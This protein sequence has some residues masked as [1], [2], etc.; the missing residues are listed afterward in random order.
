MYYSWILFDA[1]DYYI[2]FMIWMLTLCLS[3]CS[4]VAYNYF[5]YSNFAGSQTLSKLFSNNFFENHRLIR[6]IHERAGG[7]LPFLNKD[8]TRYS[9]YSWLANDKL[10]SNKLDLENLF[11][12]NLNKKW[13][14]TSHGY[15]L[16]LY[17]LTNFLDLSVMNK[18]KIR[19]GRGLEKIYLEESF[20]EFFNNYRLFRYL[21]S[22]QLFPSLKTYNF[23]TKSL[24]SVNYTFLDNLYDYNLMEIENQFNENSFLIKHKK[25]LF[26]LNDLNFGDLIFKNT[27]FKEFY[28]INLNF[29]NQLDSAKWNRWLYRY[30]ILHRKI[31]K[32]S[33]KLTLTKKLINMSPNED[34]SFDKNIWLS[35]NLQK[36]SNFSNFLNSFYNIFS[37]NTSLNF[38]NFQKRTLLNDINM[39]NK[40]FLNFY[41]NSFFFFLK[42]F[43]FFNELKFNNTKSS[44]NFKELYTDSAFFKKSNTADYILNSKIVNYKTFN[45]SIIA[46]NNYNNLFLKS[47]YTKSDYENKDLFLIFEDLDFYSKDNL[48][49]LYW[50]TSLPSL[51]DKVLFFNYFNYLNFNKFF[52]NT[53]FKFLSNNGDMFSEFDYINYLILNNNDDFYLN[54]LESYNNFI[55]I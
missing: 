16:T 47:F 30:S 25:G 35:E 22:F 55:N 50:I 38:N 28:N 17:K 14:N 5:F 18:S 29:Q 1:V 24:K 46:D 37:K 23:S 43:Y 36:F 3:I 54:D 33:H 6:Y 42:R 20:H 12:V 26:Y 11:D 2:T 49:I 40:N 53:Q 48:K 51:N 52:N 27:F 8:G 39:D 41:E 7:K 19:V 44:F 4:S 10:K 45:Y 32:N 9:V 13:W 21:F 15:F 31:L 34:N